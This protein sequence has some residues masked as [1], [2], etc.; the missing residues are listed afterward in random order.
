MKNLFLRY[1]LVWVFA[2]VVRIIEFSLDVRVF[3]IWLTLLLYL[4]KSSGLLLSR[5]TFTIYAVHLLILWFILWVEYVVFP[6][7][8]CPSSISSHLS[9]IHLFTFSFPNFSND[10]FIYFDPSS[11]NS[12]CDITKNT[13][14]LLRRLRSRFY[15]AA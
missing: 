14:K 13:I 11:P 2:Q 8:S 1:Y 5:K 9:D 4:P 12:N 6:F 10:N 15:T 3:S 7:L